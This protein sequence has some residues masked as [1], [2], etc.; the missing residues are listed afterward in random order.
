MADARENQRIIFRDIDDGNRRNAC[1]ELTVHSLDEFVGHDCV[2][3]VGGVNAI[4]GEDAAEVVGSEALSANDQTLAL[5]L[6][7]ECV[8]V[9]Y[10]RAMGG[11]FIGDDLVVRE[12]VIMDSCGFGG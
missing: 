2:A 10:W 9:D 4:K 6:G 11:G 3:G 1:D 7:E 8:D 5:D 12:N